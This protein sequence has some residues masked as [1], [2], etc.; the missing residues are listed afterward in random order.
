MALYAILPPDKR[1]EIYGKR[2]ANEQYTLAPGSKRFDA[3]GKLVAEAPFAPEYRSSAQAIHS[4]KWEEVVKHLVAILM[5]ARHYLSVRT[6]PGALRS[7]TIAGRKS[8]T[9]M[10]SSFDA[11]AIPGR[12]T[13]A[14]LE[15]H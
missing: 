15:P 1:A 7:Q 2:E 14:D 9:R 10:A 4:F 8:A 12:P 5:L 13:Q 6:T 11:S 3:M